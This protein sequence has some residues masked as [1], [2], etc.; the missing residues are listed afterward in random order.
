MSEKV[1]Q[2]KIS[3]SS[4]TNQELQQ[5]VRYKYIDDNILLYLIV[6]SMVNRYS[7]LHSCLL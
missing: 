3:N 5:H 2:M 6:I 4:L 1:N 7:I